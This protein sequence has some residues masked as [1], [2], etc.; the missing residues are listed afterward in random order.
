MVVAAVGRIVV[1]CLTVVI[2]WK[3][4]PAASRPLL[5]GQLFAVVPAIQNGLQAVW[6]ATTV[7]KVRELVAYAMILFLLPNMPGI[8]QLIQKTRKI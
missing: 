5:L 3:M 7:D 8:I 1:V 6:N 4:L 2:M